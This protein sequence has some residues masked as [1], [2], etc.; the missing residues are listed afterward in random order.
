MKAKTSR[1][2]RM[3]S[4]ITAVAVAVGAILT[5]LSNLDSAVKGWCNNIGLGCIFKVSKT[6]SATVSPGNPCD[7]DYKQLCVEPT[8]KYR[9]FVVSSMKFDEKAGIHPLGNYTPGKLTDASNTG[10]YLNKTDAI[11]PEK[12]CITVF[13]RTGACERKFSISGQITV[14]ERTTIW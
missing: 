8:T 7:N 5:V 12:I 3:V 14:D 2:M 6:V 10:W 9:R 13:A 11:T 1:F 4:I